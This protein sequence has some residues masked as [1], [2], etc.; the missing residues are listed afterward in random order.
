MGPGIESPRQAPPPDPIA[1]R[2]DRT[3]AGRG[4]LRCPASE[5]RSP[6]RRST[7]RD[8]PRRETHR[9]PGRRAEASLRADRVQQLPPSA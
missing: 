5:S 7:T 8:A 3:A 2:L 1:V 4:R 9:V 6:A